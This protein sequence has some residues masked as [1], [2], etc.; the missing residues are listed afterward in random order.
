MRWKKRGCSIV[1][2]RRVY[3]LNALIIIAG[4]IK[5]IKMVRH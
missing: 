3:R 5:V 4:I 2:E 1:I